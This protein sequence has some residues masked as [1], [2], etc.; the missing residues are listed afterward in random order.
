MFSDHESALPDTDVQYQITVSNTSAANNVSVVDQI[1][2][3]MTFVSVAAPV[4]WSCTQSSPGGSGLISCSIATMA[5]MT[6]VG[7]TVVLHIPSTAAEG[8]VF[9]N[10]VIVTSGTQ[11]IIDENNSAA[12]ATTVTASYVISA[13]AGT[14]QTTAINTRFASPLEVMVTVAG[15]PRAGATIVLQ[16]PSSGPSAVFASNGSLTETLVTGGNGV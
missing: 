14:N 15:S 10:S 9:T 8:D 2:A 7:L 4:G 1:P 5:A 13:S 16:A 12:T 6:D 11:D 3:G